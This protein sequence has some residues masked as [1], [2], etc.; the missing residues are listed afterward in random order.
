MPKTKKD[1]LEVI[2]R[3]DKLIA[4]KRDEDVNRELSTR[5]SIILLAQKLLELKALGYTS[6]DLVGAL[7]KEGIVIKGGTLGR[8]LHDYQLKQ[9]G[10]LSAKSEK[11]SPS[12][13]P[14]VTK[15]TADATEASSVGQPEVTISGPLQADIQALSNLEGQEEIGGI[16]G[17]ADDGGEGQQE[18]EEVT[19]EAAPVIFDAITVR[20][21]ESDEGGTQ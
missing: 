13:S 14:D 12:G 9:A 16:Q 8:Y 6:K 21:S 7:A 10:H 4:S 17:F 5:E 2:K 15:P 3:L 19:P 18:V 1:M 20:Q 11:P